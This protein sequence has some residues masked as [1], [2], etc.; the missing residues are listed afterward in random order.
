[1]YNTTSLYKEQVK[2]L[3]QDYKMEIEV[4][5]DEGTGITEPIIIPPEDI[6]EAGYAEQIFLS[7]FTVGTTSSPTLWIRIFNRDGKYSQNALSAAELHPYFTLYDESGNSTD[8]VPVGVFFIEKLIL[9]NSDIRLNC[10][11]KMRYCERLYNVRNTQRTLYEVALEIAQDVRGSL[12]N[13]IGEFPL[14]ARSVDDNI[15]SGYSKRQILAVIAECLGSFAVFNSEGNLEFRWFK[16]TDIELRGDWANAPLELN[17]NTFSLDGNAVKTTGVRIVYEDTETARA[18]T[19][20]YML[21]IS[22]NPVAGLFPKEVAAFVYARLAPMKYIPCKWTRI[23]GD[24]SLQI[25]DILTVIDNKEPYS[26]ENYGL[27]DKYPL[28]MTSRSWHF[29]G[30]FSD[31]YYSDGNADMDLNTDKGMTT[32]KKIAQLAKR[33]TETKKDITADMDEREKALLMFNE[34][35]AGSM[36]LYQTVREENGSKISYMHD[37]PLLEDSLTIYTYGANGFA[38]TDAGWNNGEPLW[39]YGFDRN[40]NAILNAIYAYTLT[41][42]VINSGMLMS[43]NKASWINMNNGEFCFRTADIIDEWYGDGGNIE[44]A[45]D[46]KTV[47]ELANKVLNIYGTLRSVRYPELSVSIGTSETGND[48]AFT[49]T[50]KSPGYGDLFQV[51]GITSAVGNGTVWTAPFLINPAK[52]NRKGIS[53]LPNDIIL[54]NDDSNGTAGFTNNTVHFYAFYDNIHWTNSKFNWVWF[55]YFTPKEGHAPSLY[56]FGNGTNGGFG[57]IECAEVKCTSVNSSGY[58]VFKDV[59]RV[60]GYARIDDYLYIGGPGY[61][62]QSFKL[63]VHGT[64]VADSWVVNSDRELKENIVEISDVEALDKVNQLK[65]YSY[66]FKKT[67]T[68]KAKALNSAGTPEA[69]EKTPTHIEMGIMADEAPKEIQCEGGKQIDL[70]AY[71]SLVAKS[72]QELTAIVNEQSRKI[73]DLEKLISELKQ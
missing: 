57:G 24:P 58:G 55:N 61:Q 31:K 2:K 30:S 65:F 39:H 62:G 11:D 72:V 26:E 53:I 15:F 6:F 28:Y 19:D 69:K 67:D 56:R 42:D 59:L 21:T 18:G 64:S 33:I 10:I 73:A 44:Y 12:V 29:N 54:F 22:E 7:K 46:Y 27:Y 51:Y 68:P 20:E 48:G 47:L 4:I 50:D 71:T 49:V 5:L 14:L 32:P 41:A 1:M 45:Y 37:K 13:T 9:Q 52:T 60:L 17:G 23:G 3:P 34:A 25:G 35:I 63:T 38:W 43:Q 40:G 16:N 8:K 70:Y 66:D 36:G